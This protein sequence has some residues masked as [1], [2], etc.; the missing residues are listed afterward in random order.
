MAAIRREQKTLGSLFAGI[1]GFDLG[2]EKAGFKT[3][4]QVEINPIC[5]AVLHAR[6]PQAKQY[7][8]VRKV[9]R[10]NLVE[11]VD[12]ITAGFPCQDVSAMGKRRGLAGERTGLF[13]EVC[14]VVED[15]RPKW[16]VLE[17]VVGLLS[18]NDGG[19]FATVINAL[20]DRGYVGL[21][22]VLN[23]SGFGVPQRRRRVFVV[24]GDGVQPPAE[25]LFDAAPVDCV[26]GTLAPGEKRRAA[27]WPAYTLL[28]KAAPSLIP[29]GVDNLVAHEGRRHQMVE[30][31]RSARRAGLCL[32][33][34][35][36]DHFEVRAAGNAVAVPVAQW[37]A[38]KLIEM[39]HG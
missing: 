12:V 27:D 21:W 18:S 36:T 15:I 13:W 1:G 38:S 39:Q 16:L 23:A 24:A 34:A 28:A 37:I 7:D 9:N 33:L 35:E 3:V 20:A 32:G 17:N 2:F 14:R 22:R 26:P 11:R 19:D 25:L 29:L 10:E 6:F 31:A 4:W 30:R 8:D 5:R